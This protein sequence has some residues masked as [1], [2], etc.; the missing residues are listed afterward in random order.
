MTKG[1]LHRLRVADNLEMHHALR[2]L[3]RLVLIPEDTDLVIQQ[4]ETEIPR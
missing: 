2:L 3:R 4:T 1:G